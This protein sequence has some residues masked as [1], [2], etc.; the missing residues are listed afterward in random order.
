MNLQNLIDDFNSGDT[1]EV[2]KYFN[3][4]PTFLTIL[5]KRGL[6][7]E[8]D[9]DNSEEWENGYLMWLYKKDKQSFIKEVVSQLNND[10][11]LD[12]SGKI[13]LLLSDRSDLADL[14]CDYR[15]GSGQETVRRLL[16]EE[17]VF[18]PF[19]ETTDDVYRDVIQE[20]TPENDKRLQDYIIDTLKDIEIETETEELS[21]IADEQGHPEYVIVTS[22]NVKRIIDD[23]E[24]M[25]LLLDNELEELRSELH[26]IHNNS[27]NSAYESEVWDKVWEELSTYF[28]DNGEWLEK[29]HPYKENTQIYIFKLPVNDTFEKNILDFLDSYKDSGSYGNLSY[30]GS[31]L[32]ILSDGFDCLHLS[33]PDYPNFSLVDKNINEMFAD[34]I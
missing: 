17:D 22:E 20:L 14:F 29:P 24:T 4:I 13:F 23:E 11:T 31:Y 6:I 16:S 30:F 27:F 1:E 5:D 9:F 8:L 12:E 32:G 19:W 28:E 18:Y 34:Y 15:D 21:L 3:D 10:L 26:N 2:I 7:D 25:N 33:I